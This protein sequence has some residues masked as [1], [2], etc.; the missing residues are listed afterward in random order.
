MGAAQEAPCCREWALSSLPLPEHRLV[1]FSR[2]VWSGDI[3]VVFRYADS[4]EPPSLVCLSGVGSGGRS[5]P[6]N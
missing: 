2:V 4:S 3:N 6:I 5:I 1:L